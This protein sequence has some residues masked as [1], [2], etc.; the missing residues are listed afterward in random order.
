MTSE[1]LVTHCHKD[2]GLYVYI[3]IFYTLIETPL[4]ISTQYRDF[5]FFSFPE[6]QGIILSATLIDRA[7]RLHLTSNILSASK[8]L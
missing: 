6:Q 8:I 1:A 3:A 5:F 7:K 2:L 4:G